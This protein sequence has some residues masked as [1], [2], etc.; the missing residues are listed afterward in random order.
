MEHS[1]DTMPT[2]VPDGRLKDAIHRARE[3]QAERTDVLVD[4]RDAE[5]ARL[6]VLHG[7]LGDSLAVVPADNDMFDIVLSRGNKPRLWIDMLAF[8]VMGRD[9][10]TYRFM[11]DTRDGRQVLFESTDPDAVST[12]IHDY[13]AHRIIERE[14]ALDAAGDFAILPA[15]AGDDAE[16]NAGSARAVTDRGR[17]FGSVL[18][19]FI[20]GMIAGVAV[21]LAYGYI[22]IP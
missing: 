6:E 4:L 5:I 20:L 10:R 14:K 13:A 1:D 15:E 3:E 16:D 22:Q 2:P 12:R 18:A 21:L 7:N 8:V 11:R 19:S 17:G 9:R